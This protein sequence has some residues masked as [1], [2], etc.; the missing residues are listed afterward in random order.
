MMMT[1][2]KKNLFK[3]NKF[4]S[5]PRNQNWKS[6]GKKNIFEVILIFQWS[7]FASDLRSI[8]TMKDAGEERA[9][10]GGGGNI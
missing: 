3:V 6:Q 1:T 2:M 8:P 5:G 4:I 9:R 10:G 7:W